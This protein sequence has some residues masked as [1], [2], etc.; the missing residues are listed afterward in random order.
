M[1][2]E[3]L[4]LKVYDEVLQQVESALTSKSIEYRLLGGAAVGRRYYP[5]PTCRHNQ[6]IE[7]LVCESDVICASDALH[8]LKFEPQ[9]NHSFLHVTGLPLH[10]R[11]QLI[12][13][14]FAVS[15][16]TCLRDDPTVNLCVAD[17]LLDVVGRAAFDP[18]STNLLWIFDL[19]F[20]LAANE[21]RDWRSFVSSARQSGL[22][23]FYGVALR[24][25]N[26]SLSANV[27]EYVVRELVSCDDGNN[28]TTQVCVIAS[29]IS[30]GRS[31]FDMW[32]TLN[33]QPAL[34][35]R[36]LIFLLYPP[37]RF[38]KWRYGFD[39][40]LSILRWRLERPLR[41]ARRLRDRG[42][43]HYLGD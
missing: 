15:K 43:R 18:A 10:L 30:R 11:T 14:P 23:T 24:Y 35:F 34:A 37:A 4:R 20:M 27:P 22:G 16:K 19:W 25:V 36:Y 26:E 28:R 12:S 33:D 6:S 31:E 21:V 9:F 17:L 1:L 41:I 32:K 40:K 3:E 5:S 42:R 29:M 38:L 7:L 2:R 13:M 8:E 39:T